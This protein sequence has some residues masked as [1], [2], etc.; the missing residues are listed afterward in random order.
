M[1]SDYRLSIID[2]RLDGMLTQY[3]GVFEKRICAPIFMCIEI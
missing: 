2:Y 3:Y 1:I